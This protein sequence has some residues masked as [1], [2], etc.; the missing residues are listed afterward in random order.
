MGAMTAASRLRE[1]E[2]V[3][4][5]PT[6]V[7]RIF[8]CS[9]RQSHSACGMLRILQC[10]SHAVCRFGKIVR[11]NDIRESSWPAEHKITSFTEQNFWTNLET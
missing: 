4:E 8:D 9:E 6:G 2:L 1:W 5:T 11:S 3:R 7:K 10:K